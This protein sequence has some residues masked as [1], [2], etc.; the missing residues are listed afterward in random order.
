MTLTI[1]SKCCKG[2]QKT[3]Y[4]LFVIAFATFIIYCMSVT[5]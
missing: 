5:S 1:L 3:G 4:A 2:Y